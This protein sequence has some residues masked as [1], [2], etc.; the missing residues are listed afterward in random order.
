MTI[1]IL[2]CG[3][4]SLKFSL[5]ELPNYRTLTSG[6]I[7]RVGTDGAFIKF[8]K[9][10]GENSLHSRRRMEKRK[11]NTLRSKTIQKALALF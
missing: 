11:H 3:S 1:L 6:L 9:K 10:N 8:E 2:N 7:E 5:V 4:S